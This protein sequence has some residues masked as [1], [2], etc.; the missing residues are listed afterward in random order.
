MHIRICANAHP[1]LT[2]V[3]TL[4]LALPDDAWRRSGP[5]DVTG[6]RQLIALLDLTDA[7]GRAGGRLATAEPHEPRLHCK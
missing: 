2:V 5:G 7:L 4:S 6:E 1:P 3:N